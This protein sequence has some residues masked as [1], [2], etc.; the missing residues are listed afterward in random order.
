MS[1]FILEVVD[2]VQPVDRRAAMATDDKGISRSHPQ[3]IVEQFPLAIGKTTVHP[4]GLAAARGWLCARDDELVAFSPG[5]AVIA[6]Y[7]AIIPRN[8]HRLRTRFIACRC[9]TD[10]YGLVGDLDDDTLA[11]VIQEFGDQDHFGMG[12][13]GRGRKQKIK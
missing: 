13:G 4:V 1:F 6:V 5:Y 3:G 9:S 7:Q 10:L 8:P 11:A 2:A 12:G